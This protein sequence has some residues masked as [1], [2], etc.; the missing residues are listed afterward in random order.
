MM[1]S[2][3]QW[4]QLPTTDESAAWQLA[5]GT[6]ML[7]GLEPDGA[8]EPRTGLRW[9]TM[10][11]PAVIIGTGQPLSTSMP[12]RCISTGSSSIGAAVA[13]RLSI[14]IRSS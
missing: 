7:T 4:R 5:G 8:T 13:A 6:A 3:T 9:Y 14:P 2:P 11:A 10:H 12:M 1:Y